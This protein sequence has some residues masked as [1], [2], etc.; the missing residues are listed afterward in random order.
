MAPFGRNTLALAL[1]LGSA[2]MFNAPT[3]AAVQLED[4]QLVATTPV[5]LQAAPAPQSFT[6][7]TAQTLRATLTD[8]GSD[9]GV[10]AKLTSV[11][12]V[13]VSGSKS[14]LNMNKTGTIDF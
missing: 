12:L 7:T 14:V 3:R 5:L 9:V 1:A 4:A 6:V 13:V 2:M 10:P 11:S 8:L